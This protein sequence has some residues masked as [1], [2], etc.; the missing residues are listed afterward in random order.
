MNFQKQHILKI[1]NEEI[2]LFQ[3]EMNRFIEQKKFKVVKVC[4]EALKRLQ[5]MVSRIQLET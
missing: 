1:I 5:K 3:R 4:A 2:N